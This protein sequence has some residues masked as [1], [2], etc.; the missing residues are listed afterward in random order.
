MGQ[1]RNRGSYEARKAQAEY[2]L[3]QRIDQEALAYHVMTWWQLDMTKERVM[4]INKRKFTTNMLLA[5]I[6][7]LGVIKKNRPLY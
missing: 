6:A 2:K 5:T 4:S 1:A 7:G 3:Q